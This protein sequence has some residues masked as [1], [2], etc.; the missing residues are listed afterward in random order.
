METRGIK[1]TK[2]SYHQ[3]K[4]LA[5]SPNPKEK[6]GGHKKPRDRDSLGA[7]REKKVGRR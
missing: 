7:K 1:Q 6:G 5:G 4:R 3:V 2:F